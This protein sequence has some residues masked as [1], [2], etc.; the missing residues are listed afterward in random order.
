L[1]A[2]ASVVTLAAAMVV[3]AGAASA[4]PPS[5][6]PGPATA[7]TPAA[8]DAIPVSSKLAGGLA[9]LKTGR[10]Q[11]FVQLAG[12]GAADASAAAA[13][14]GAA[15]MKAAANA[16]KATT[17][18]R[19]A[20]VF[21]TARGKD[22][23]AR[24]LF[25]VGN[26]I[27][28]FAVDA[29]VA[30]IQAMAAS[31]DVVKI[32]PLVPKTY[33]N[34]NGEELTNVLSTWQDTGTLGAGV[35][36]GIIDTGIDYTHADFGGPGTAAAWNSAHANNTD[37]NWY[38]TLTAKAKLKVGGGY[39]FVG[40]NYNADPTAD[41]YQP[42]PH[43]D[44]DPIDC[45]E[46]GTHVAGILGGYGENADGS[47]FTGNYAGLNS[48][49]LNAMKIGPGMAPAATIYSLKVFGC[50]GSTDEVIPA[51][52]WALDPNGDGN[53]SDHLDIVNLS[54]GSD[55]G[56][57][58]DPENAVVDQLAKH[59]VLPVIAMG[60]AGDLTDI[61]GSP[62]NAL[63]SL[64]VASSVDADQPMD[65]LRVNAPVGVAGVVA[66][67]F[68]VAYPWSSAAPVTGSVV[69]LSAANSDGCD[70]LS[71]ADAAAVTGKVAWLTWD[72]NDATRRCGSAG[73]SANVAAAGA[74]GAVFTGDVDP[75]AAGITGSAAIPVVQLTVTATAALQSAV[76]AGTLNVTFDG[77][78]ALSQNSVNPA[79]TDTISSFSSRGTHG[80]IG[81]VKP[82]V[83]AP[84]D[85]ILS[86]GMGLGAGGLVLSGTSMATPH[87]AGIAALV[88]A[89]HRDWSAEQVKAAIM[90]TA[91]H[92]VYSQPGQTGPIYGPA[93]DGAGR[94][95]ALAAVS[96]SV[97]AYDTDKSIRGGVSASFGVVE[98]P[99]TSSTITQ[100]RTVTI[101]NTGSSS[102]TL[103]LS[104]AAAVTEPGVSYSVSPTKVTV[105][106][107]KS[108]TVRV[109]LTVKPG[110]LRHS[111]DPTMAGTQVGVPRS[112]LSDA[113][114]RL[115]ISQAGKADLRV[116]VYAAVK[117]VS[118][119]AASDGTVGKG[120]SAS[121]AIELS[122]TGFSQGS[123]STAWTSLV[124]VMDLGATSPK[125]PTCRG[126]VTTNCT[127]NQ[128]ATAGDIQYV[129]AG[130]ADGWL[131]FG[132]ST[133]GNW[134]ALDNPA[135]IPYIQIDTNGDGKPD[136]EV[137]VLPYTG[138]DVLLAELFD[139]HT[140][141]NIDLEP[142]NLQWGDVDTNVYD[143]NVM[144]V[145]VDPSLLGI[146]AGASTF[147]ITYTVGMSSYLAVNS[148]GDIDDVGPIRYDVLNPKVRVGSPLYA[149]QG[150]TAIPYVLGAAPSAATAATVLGRSLNG[151]GQGGNS[152]SGGD[153]G[154]P[155]PQAASALVLHL[156][157][158]TGKRAEVVKLKG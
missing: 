140:G 122:G 21:G 129:G 56:V 28:G 76:V 22:A 52:D 54:L 118:R 104:Y 49:N 105:R 93:R 146:T 136:F 82:D 155:K 131:Y 77:S 120:K 46:H 58:D 34:T 114:G 127:V 60:N 137:D 16:A 8:H 113:S 26:A 150:H 97:I 135:L 39:D 43:P 149:D 144:V 139:L 147:P 35:K 81:V 62:G 65:G 42:V 110:Q 31:A 134:A 133:Y 98:A 106:A 73:R 13:D 112:Y 87:T 9:S 53:F 108:T 4:S 74:I 126:K 10:K 86:A 153:H 59:G 83:A 37:P 132:I 3:G 23:K 50:T 138:T 111:I 12:E 18:N 25:Q 123:G 89:T 142:L 1:L 48:A 61:G 103:S 78:L 107:G 91:G 55:Y 5:G 158:A 27:P 30:A 95:D 71:A 2:A 67:Q 15:G 156:H 85:S 101:Q 66:A 41:D 19:S 79:V 14:Q 100:N 70:P 96:T 36:V 130:T 151:A 40:D 64:A 109:T 51:L 63:G 88:K 45:A 121:P 44:P 75:F 6:D 68:S 7:V 72:S 57:A 47:T 84:G 90:N 148:N 69:A 115:L 102:V 124:S 128:S 32:S 24:Q 38:S 99:V 29:D 145:P 154:K 157:G 125:L 117:P 20:A 92:D 80:S 152:Q 11:V 33:Q 141:K 17:K 116:P 119:T 143:S 94:V